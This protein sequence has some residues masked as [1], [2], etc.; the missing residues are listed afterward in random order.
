MDW[1]V[2]SDHGRID[3]IRR[4]AR[5][6]TWTAE[7]ILSRIGEECVDRG[8]AADLLSPPERWVPELRRIASDAGRPLLHTRVRAGGGTCCISETRRAPR[9]SWNSFGARIPRI[10]AREC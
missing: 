9:R 5:D 8:T 10:A 2:T 1:E 7:K 3:E 6:Q 4:R